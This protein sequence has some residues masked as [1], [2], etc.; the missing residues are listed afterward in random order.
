MQEKIKDFGLTSISQKKCFNV[1]DVKNFFIENQMNRCVI[2]PDRGA[3]TETTYLC[4]TLDNLVEKFHIIMKSNKNQADVKKKCCVVQEYIDGEEWIVNTITRNGYHKIINVMKYKKG[5]VNGID[6]VYLETRLIDPN[7]VPENLIFYVKNVLHA[8]EIKYGAAH[9][10]VKMSSRGPC[11]I[12]V[13]ARVGGGQNRKFIADCLSPSFNG[14]KYNQESSF[15]YA[16]LSQSLFDTIPDMYNLEKNGATIWCNS[17]NNNIIWKNVYIKKLLDKL[18]DLV[19]VREIKFTYKENEIVKKTID[20]Y[21]DLIDFEIISENEENIDK[22][23]EI[24]REWENNFEKIAIQNGG[25]MNIFTYFF[26]KYPG[27]FLIS[28][29]IFLIC[30]S[31]IYLFEFK[32]NLKLFK[33]KLKRLK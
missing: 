7:D 19:I 32:L 26:K 24:I 11:L 12:E 3:A 8:L 1:D 15:I 4:N 17:K 16:Y 20:F 22:A 2:K 28:I 29:I 25:K 30:I 27:F 10:E 14:E 9:S 31:F 33:S 6:F 23:I 13:G 21:T 5:K 18:S